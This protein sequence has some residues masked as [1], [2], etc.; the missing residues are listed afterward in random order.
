M[1]DTHFRLRA[2]TLSDRD[3]PYVT[4]FIKQMLRNKNKLMQSN[5][6]DQANALAGRI[7]S[8]INNF[9]AASL[10]KCNHRLNSSD[11]WAK[12][13]Q[14]LHKTRETANCE[15]VTALSLNSHFTQISTD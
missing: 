12:G 11:M 6:I 15:S 3:P 13:N 2:I 10:R 4:P 5:K 9:N 8:A 1:L 7:G 14:L